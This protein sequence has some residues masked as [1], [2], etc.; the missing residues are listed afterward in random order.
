M[1]TRAELQQRVAEWPDAAGDSSWALCFASVV[2]AA[3]EMA[4]LREAAKLCDRVVLARLT[5][6]RVLPPTY[7]EVASAAGADLLWCPRELT[8]HVRADVGVEGVDGITS[9]LLLQAITT[10][11]P[12]LVVA[13]RG[14]LPLVRA[15]RNMLHGL[16]DMFVL[17]VV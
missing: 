8:G 16:G 11:L 1:T 12:N 10:V 13:P 15:L 5:P 3:G 2:P 9:T 17:R 6:D 4:A 14:N 7:A